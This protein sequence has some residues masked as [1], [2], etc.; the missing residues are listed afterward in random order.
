MTSS[1]VTI[2]LN[3]ETRE[4]TQGVSLVDLLEH[5]GLDPTKVAVERNLEVVP[6]SV[7]AETKLDGGDRIEIVQF[8]GGG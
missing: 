3:G 1:Q 5:L 4:I 6:K 7:Y 2:Q 8:I